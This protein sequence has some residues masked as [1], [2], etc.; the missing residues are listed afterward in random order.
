[1]TDG[2]P[3]SGV[4]LGS[5]LPE[6]AAGPD[7]QE[8]E[9][10]DFN[11]SGDPDLDNLVDSSTNDACVLEFD[12]VC[13]DSCNIFFNYVFGSE[14]YLE[15]VGSEYN[16]VFGLFVDNENIAI[17]PFSETVVSINTVNSDNNEDFF[18]NNIE[19]ENIQADGFTTLLTASTTVGE[20]TS[21]VKFAVADAADHILDTWLFIQG[22]TLQLSSVDATG[23]LD[24]SDES[25]ISDLVGLEIIS[26]LNSAIENPPSSS[27]LL[28]GV[29]GGT[30]KF[31]ASKPFT[32]ISFAYSSKNNLVMKLFSES[33]V[34]LDEIQ[35]KSTNNGS[36]SSSTVSLCD[37]KQE[38]KALTGAAKKIEIIPE[39][40]TIQL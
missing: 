19:Y 6:A 7:D 9:T 22:Q 20:G 10:F 33:N 39:V 1:M 14:E 29:G 23:S 3:E 15:Y 27:S 4:I 11:T 2:F 34:L 18:V 16:D 37:W 35:L 5:G 8:D 36:C 40:F 31:V 30:S 26:S 12:I 25:S 17:L 28:A 32:T 38:I 24:L 13:P 21:H